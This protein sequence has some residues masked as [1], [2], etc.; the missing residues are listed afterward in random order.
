MLDYRKGKE[1]YIPNG[2]GSLYVDKSKINSN[3]RPVIYIGGQMEH[4]CHVMEQTGKTFDPGH[5][6][7]AGNWFYDY[8]IFSRNKGE[9]NGENFSENLIE[10]LTMAKLSDVDLITHSFGG[11]IGSLAS[12]SDRIHK[13][14]AVHPP[15]TGTPLANPKD[16]E[17]Y[18]R[19]LNKKE[20]LLLKVL[21]VLVNTNY[22]FEHDN[23][24]GVDLIKIDLNKL[25][26]IG[27]SLDPSVEKGFVLDLY[28]MVKKVTGLENDGVVTYS[29]ELLNRFG[30]NYV[31]ENVKNNHFNSGTEEAFKYAYQISRT[32]K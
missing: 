2:L 29:E 15:I 17:E 20:K 18:K 10:S 26:V 14:Y 7:F 1:R 11:I 3:E 22:G 27:S 31:T 21:K 19:L 8:S 6:M 25:V 24:N 23:Y 28:N 13:V 5:N 30:I 4:R 16:I 32:M 12:K 9:I